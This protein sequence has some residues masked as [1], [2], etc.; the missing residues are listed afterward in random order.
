M[1][2]VDENKFGLVP[3]LWTLEPFA[4]PRSMHPARRDAAP[5]GGVRF[6]CQQHHRASGKEQT[7]LHTG[8]CGRRL[9]MSLPLKFQSKKATEVCSKGGERGTDREIVTFQNTDSVVRSSV[10]PFRILILSSDPYCF[11]RDLLLRPVAGLA[12][13]FQS[14]RS[15]TRKQKANQEGEHYFPSSFLHRKT[16]Q[17]VCK[18]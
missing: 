18:R 7:S 14:T 10:F 13:D 17:I 2:G 9:L 5:I 15:L 4:S 12:P 6:G 1:G 8:R 11:G 16:P 3:L